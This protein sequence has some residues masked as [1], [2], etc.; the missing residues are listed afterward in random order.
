VGPRFE[1]QRRDRRSRAR[2]PTVPA[3]GAENAVMSRTS[4][5]QQGSI[6]PSFYEAGVGHLLAALSSSS[7]AD[8]MK[9][10][11]GPLL[12]EAA[13]RISHAIGR[14]RDTARIGA[15]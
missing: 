8:R 6:F 10:S 9:T 3:G 7:P 2:E 14:R 13:E 4:V 15:A 11:W 5:R 12:K 1:R